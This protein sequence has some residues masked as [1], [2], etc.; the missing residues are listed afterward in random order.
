VFGALWVLI[1]PR[2][3]HRPVAAADS[4]Q[5]RTL[6]DPDRACE[7]CHKDIYDRYKQT[8]MA[9]GSGVAVDWL[10]EG[11]FTHTAS[12]IRYRLAVHDGQAWMSY[13]RSTDRPQYS[14]AA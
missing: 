10:I 5:K 7:G 13:Q 11:G 2:I 14:E 9:R 12:G 8:P 1:W 4:G 6:N 3:S